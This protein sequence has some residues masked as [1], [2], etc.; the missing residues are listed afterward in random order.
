MGKVEATSKTQQQRWYTGTIPQRMH[1]VAG[2]AG[3]YDM[4]ETRG[5]SRTQVDACINDGKKV[6]A[7]L[8][9]SQADNEK[10]GVDSTPSF[11][12]NGKTL[13]VHSWDELRPMLASAT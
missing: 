10:Y 4:M 6:D 13:D 11:V 12:L 2:D 8:K 7:L 1:A 9:Q 5:Y 3:F